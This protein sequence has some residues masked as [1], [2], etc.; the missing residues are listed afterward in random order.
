MVAADTQASEPSSHLQALHRAPVV[1]SNS[2]GGLGL[3]PVQ[4]PLPQLSS[5]R[6]ARDPVLTLPLTPPI[7]PEST[8]PGYQTAHLTAETAAEQ[9]GGAAIL[10]DASCPHAAGG[11]PKSRARHADLR[12]AARR[13]ARHASPE[14]WAGSPQ[15]G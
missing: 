7:M 2:S 8:R 3:R 10:Q 11:A 1:K 12:D 9:D 14:G 6:E 13:K 15:S 5:H 4:L